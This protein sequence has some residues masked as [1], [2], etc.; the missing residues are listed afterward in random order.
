MIQV[1]IEM[2][3]SGTNLQIKAQVPPIVALAVVTSAYHELLSKKFAADYD[4]SIRL[5]RSLPPRN[6]G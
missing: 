6:G 5:A 1:V 3:E 4:H 2:D